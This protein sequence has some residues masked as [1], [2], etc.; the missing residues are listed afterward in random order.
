MSRSKNRYEIQFIFCGSVEK[1]IVNSSSL[2]N[3]I[4]E[5]AKAFP[6]VNIIGAFETERKNRG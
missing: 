1:R 6:E 3:A 4:I 5:F 2:C